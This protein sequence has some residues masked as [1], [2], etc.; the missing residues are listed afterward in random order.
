MSVKIRLAMVG[1]RKQR[2]YRIVAIESRNARDGKFL[3]R[4]GWYDPRTKEL[5]LNEAGIM[6]WKEKGAIISGRVTKLL[7]RWQTMEKKEVDSNEG[8]D[9]IHS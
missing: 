7:K 1:K 4:L 6:R 5:Q 8:A 3:E 2:T 9:N